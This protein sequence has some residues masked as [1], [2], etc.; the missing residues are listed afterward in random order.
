MG[1]QTGGLGDLRGGPTG[2]FGDIRGERA[3]ACSRVR[4]GRVPPRALP[5]RMRAAVALASLGGPATSRRLTARVANVPQAATLAASVLSE[6]RPGLHVRRAS[7]ERHA[8]TCSYLPPL[9]CLLVAC[10]AC[11]G[12]GLAQLATKVVAAEG[13]RRLHMQEAVP[14]AWM[15]L[16]V[17]NGSCF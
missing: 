13:P 6:A 11:C 17:N 7:H 14:A 9:A 16:Q 5:P 12:R 8:P 1:G 4:A 15:T 10:V 2:T 3:G